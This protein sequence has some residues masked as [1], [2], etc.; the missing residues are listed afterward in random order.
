MNVNPVN[1]YGYS[2]IDYTIHR[3]R[4]EK[5]V[6]FGD[7]TFHAVYVA[8]AGIYDVTLSNEKVLKTNLA[9]PVYKGFPYLDMFNKG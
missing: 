3:V 8:N 2:D 1:F 6:H 9:F 7:Y 5:F 4:T